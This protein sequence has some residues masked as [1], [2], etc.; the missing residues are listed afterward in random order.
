MKYL[1][2][3]EVG[4]GDGS[5]ESLIK[6]EKSNSPTPLLYSAGDSWLF[7]GDLF[8]DGNCTGEGVNDSVGFAYKISPRFPIN[9]NL[10]AYIV[11][12]L[13]AYFFGITR[14]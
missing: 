4:T 2:P 13:L 8:F 14:K 5:M 6:I 10:F 7:A 3:E 1:S 11:D 9:E 12:F